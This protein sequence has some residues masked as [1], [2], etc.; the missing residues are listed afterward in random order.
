MNSSSGMMALSLSSRI[1]KPLKNVKTL[2][3]TKASTSSRITDTLASP[4]GTVKLTRE[5]KI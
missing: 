3:A 4:L 2:A 5:G 1:L